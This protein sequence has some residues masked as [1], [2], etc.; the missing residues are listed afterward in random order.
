MK[1]L[2]HPPEH[3]R[4]RHH[5]LPILGGLF[6]GVWLL[7]F[8]L[9]RSLEPEP[10]PPRPLPEVPPAFT[11]LMEDRNV[12]PEEAA[13]HMVEA[14]IQLE[15]QGNPNMVGSQGE[16]GLMQIMEKTWVEVT[17]RHFGERISFDRAF[18]P[19]LNKRV[20]RLYLGDL[21]VYLYGHRDKWKSD[22]RTLLFACYNGGPDRVRKAGFDVDK[23]PKVIRS[24]AARGSAL[25]DWS[26]GDRSEEMLQKI[27]EAGEP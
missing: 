23:L 12:T 8:I 10:S 3:T 27:L 1:D 7:I 14:V 16:R 25:H 26:F 5:R 19:E 20:G 11:E 13:D 21:Q 4:L 9:N 6:A 17:E 18:E 15:S 24:Y 22:L 2:A